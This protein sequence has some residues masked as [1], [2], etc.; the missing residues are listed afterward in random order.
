LS[1]TFSGKWTKPKIFNNC[2][3]K[4]TLIWGIKTFYIFFVF[5]EFMEEEEEEEEEDIASIVQGST[6][7]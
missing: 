7:Q 2:T 4:T 5:I 3:W 1:K 6:F